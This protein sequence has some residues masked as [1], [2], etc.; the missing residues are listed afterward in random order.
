MSKMEQTHLPKG[1]Y[2]QAGW[3]QPP[4]R[5]PAHLDAAQLPQAWAFM[6]NLARNDLR[7]PLTAFRTTIPPAHRYRSVRVLFLHRDAE[8]VDDCLQELEK[9]RFVVQSDVVPTLADRKS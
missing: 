8:I 9:A 1:Q 5:S 2:L 6:S 4:S 7:S 3:G